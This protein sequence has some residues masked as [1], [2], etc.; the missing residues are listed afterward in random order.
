MIDLSLI[1]LIR[2]AEY[3]KFQKNQSTDPSFY[4]Q[5]IKSN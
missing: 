3:I 5:I 4:Q 1:F 2:P